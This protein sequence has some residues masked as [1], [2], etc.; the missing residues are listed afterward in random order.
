MSKLY[1]KK[2]TYD[3]LIPTRATKG[4]AGYDIHSNEDAEIK[5]VLELEFL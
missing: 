2:L 1:V 4:S 3:A 5:Y